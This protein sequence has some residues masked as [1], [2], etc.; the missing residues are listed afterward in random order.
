MKKII[1]DNR[2][3]LILA[4]IILMQVLLVVS[5]ASKKEG[6]FIDEVLS[7]S[8]SN[9]PESGF[10]QPPVHVWTDKE[11]YLKNVAAQKETSFHYDIAYHNAAED[12]T[13]PLFYMLLHSVCSLYPGHLSHWMGIAVNLFFYIGSIVLLYLLGKEVFHDK[14]FGLMIAFLFGITYGAINSAIFLRMYMMATFMLLLHLFV[15]IH[16]FEKEKIPVQGYILFIISAILG[17]LT[18]YYFLVGA[19]FLGVWYVIKFLFKKRYTELVK[20]MLSVGVSAV[21]AIIIFPAMLRHILKSGRG[22]EAIENFLDGREYVAHLRGMFRILSDELFGGFLPVLVLVLLLGVAVLV[23]R[24]K[25]TVL[26]EKQYLG[27][28][29]LTCAGY[30]VVV[31]KVAPYQVDRYMMP[32]F[33]LIYFLIVGAAYALISHFA[34]KRK[35]VI[36]CL[37]FFTALSVKQLSEYSFHYLYEGYQ[38]NNVAQDHTDEYCIVISDDHGYWYYDLQ[39]LSQYRGFYWLKDTDHIELMDNI[40]EKIDPEGE[41]VLYGK[42]T[43]SQ[44]EITEYISKYFG[45]GW[46][47]E[48]LEEYNN[49]RFMIY[50]CTRE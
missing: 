1:K 38:K 26:F 25:D 47:C 23:W 41:F 22:T 12:V 11:W 9:R 19:A 46:N 29:L 2:T 36:F 20:Y 30:F 28:I 6:Y 15:Y 34:D 43:W 31:T 10:F 17:S 45:T 18:Q 3:I 7:Y 49:E 44:E 21:T 42:N 33:P 16:Y 37:L 32:I 8:L 40:V 13:P 27:P 50:H 39:A 48:K 24:K 14:K 5:Y 4:F 35:A